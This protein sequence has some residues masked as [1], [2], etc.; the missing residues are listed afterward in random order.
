MSMTTNSDWVTDWTTDEPIVDDGDNLIP[1]GVKCNGN[2]MSS[3]IVG[4]DNVKPHSWPWIV[5]V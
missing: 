1:N 2:L 5:K 4:G 3:K